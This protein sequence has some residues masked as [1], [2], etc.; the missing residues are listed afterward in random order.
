MTPRLGHPPPHWTTT[1]YFW[2]YP[3]AFIG[4]I[5]GAVFESYWILWAA[6]GLMGAAVLPMAIYCT[7]KGIIIDNGYPLP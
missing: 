6:V 3:F 7:I 1:L 2:V 5:L 4:I